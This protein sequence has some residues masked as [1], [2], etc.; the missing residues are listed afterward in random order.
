[1]KVKKVIKHL[2]LVTNSGHSVS[3]LKHSRGSRSLSFKR[4]SCLTLL[5]SPL[6]LAASW[7][8]TFSSDHHAWARERCGLHHALHGLFCGCSAAQG[9]THSGHVCLPGTLWPVAVGVHRRHRAPRGHPGV[10][11]Q[12]AQP[13]A[14]THELCV[15]NH[16]LQLHVVCLWLF[17]ATR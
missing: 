8:G 2:V 7:C 6:P 15:F 11:A 4:P 16:T 9:W 14:A 3:Y 13:T 1:M 17:C 12:L 5:S 10:P